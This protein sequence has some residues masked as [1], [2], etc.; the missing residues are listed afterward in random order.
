MLYV[1]FKYIKFVGG[2]VEWIAYMEEREKLQVKPDDDDTSMEI[3][4][5]K[6]SN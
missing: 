4:D 2:S 6:R 3:K 5:M 1:Y